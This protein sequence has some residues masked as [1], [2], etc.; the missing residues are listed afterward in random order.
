M[1]KSV[2]GGGGEEILFPDFDSHIYL[3]SLYSKFYKI[4]NSLTQ[5][6]P[7]TVLMLSSLGDR[8]SGNNLPSY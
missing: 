2:G 6:H 3:S 1:K 8:H 5:Y 4:K 7:T